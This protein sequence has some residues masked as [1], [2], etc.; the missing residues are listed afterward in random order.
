MN[1][2]H[3]SSV[4]HPKAQ[5]GE[6]CQIGPFCVVGEQVVL[7]AN[8]TLHSHVVIEG[9]TRLGSG[10]EIFPFACLGGKTQDLKWKGG[11]TRTEIGDNN[12]FREGVTVHCATN[13]NEATVI[14][15]N[16]LFL[17]HSHVAHDCIIRNNVIMS[18]VSGLA[19]HVR[20]DDH[21]II[22]AYAGV[23]QF[24]RVGR[25]AIVGGYSKV[26][27]DVPPFMLV[28]GNPAETRTVNKI[29]LER[30][31]V[32]DATITALRQ[33]YKVLFREGLTVSNALTRIEAELPALPEIN[34]LVEFCRSSER[35]ISK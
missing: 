20:V 22:S 18:G 2:I 12:V 11:V 21:A 24:C 13:D 23:H 8:C 14:G 30:H 33:A 29:G 31:G 10:N 32:P 25:H 15:N 35:G 17:I 6:G 34:H 5:I 27:Q 26:V 19:G 4:I 3:S 16:N 1:D 9:H 7:G 28:D